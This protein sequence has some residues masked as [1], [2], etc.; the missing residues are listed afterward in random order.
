MSVHREQWRHQLSAALFLGA[1]AAAFWRVPN[2]APAAF[3]APPAAS[4]S[5]LPALFSVDQLPTATPAGA[6]SLAALPDGRIAA[7]WAAAEPSAGAQVIRYSILG[8]DGWSPPVIIASRESTAGG[9]FAHVRD[10]GRPLLHAEGG[11][12]HLWYASDG[13]LGSWLNHSRSTDGGRSW[14]KPARLPTSPLAAGDTQ[15]GNA[16]VAL[17]DGGLGL[18]LAPQGSAGDCAWLRLA[19]TGD[20]IDKTRLTPRRSALPAAVVA[21]DEKRALAVLGETGNESGQWRIARSDDGGRSWQ[22]NAALPLA[23]AG[24]P[25][26]LLR[27]KSGR[28]LLAGHPAGRPTELRLWLSADDGKTWQAGRTLEDA[29]DPALLL[30]RDGRIHLAYG[31]DRGIEHAAFSEAWLDGGAP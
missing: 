26:A 1:L 24:T 30:G 4:P 3:A 13:V 7:A 14:S 15:P 23:L 12:L 6:P 10:I 18:P 21:L 27:L 29:A 17:A 28:L 9:T 16:A 5:P 22:D 19:A 31:G 11:W 8:R 20:I 25:L 2:P